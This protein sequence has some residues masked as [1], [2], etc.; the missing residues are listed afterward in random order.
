MPFSDSRFPSE[1]G[2]AADFEVCSER[3]SLVEGVGQVLPQRLRQEERDGPSDDG[4]R[5]HDHQRQH[6]AVF[7]LEFGIVLL[8]AK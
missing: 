3:L 7:T 5:P 2:A 4:Q 6:V 1:V 8:T